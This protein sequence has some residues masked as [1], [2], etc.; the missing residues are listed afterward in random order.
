MSRDAY[1]DAEV[2]AVKLL[3]VQ[4]Q[5]AEA[6]AKALSMYKEMKEE[7]RRGLAAAA[8]VARARRVYLLVR[9][10]GPWAA[11]DAARRAARSY[12]DDVT[13]EAYAPGDLRTFFQSEVPTRQ[14]P[15]PQFYEGGDAIRV[16]AEPIL[17]E[18]D[19]WRFRLGLARA[20]RKPPSL[21][22]LS[23]NA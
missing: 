12:A 14:V 8:V 1:M 2:E 4:G 15:A 5:E 16:R 13:S 6:K 18:A 19:K 20:R 7:A 10:G 21:G 22:R 23:S 17:D 9:T 3:Y 11:A